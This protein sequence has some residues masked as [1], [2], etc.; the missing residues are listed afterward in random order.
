MCLNARY[1][2]NPYSRRKVLVNCGKCKACLQEKA[3][4]RSNRI[5][6]NIYDGEI[7]LYVKVTNNAISPS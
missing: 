2:F 4:A 6:N 1:I 3:C 5:R 7:A